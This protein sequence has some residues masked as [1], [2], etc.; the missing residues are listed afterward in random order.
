MYI[1]HLTVV[2]ICGLWTVSGTIK[3]SLG[4]DGF[5]TVAS[6]SDIVPLSDYWLDQDE[7]TTILEVVRQ[8]SVRTI[9]A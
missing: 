9:R 3:A 6:F 1:A 5:Q 2:N 7:A 4:E 8:W